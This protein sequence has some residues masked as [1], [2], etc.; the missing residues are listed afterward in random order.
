MCM[1]RSGKKSDGDGPCCRPVV[2]Y[3]HFTCS[4]ALL[5]LAPLA[6]APGDHW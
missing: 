6:G 1:L 3:L 2:D 5:L 4:V